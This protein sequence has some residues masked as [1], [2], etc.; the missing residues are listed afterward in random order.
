MAQLESV[1][2]YHKKEK[3][4]NIIRLLSADI[5]EGKEEEEEEVLTLVRTGRRRVKAEIAKTICI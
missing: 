3:Y 2:Q 4:Q 1:Q 5:I